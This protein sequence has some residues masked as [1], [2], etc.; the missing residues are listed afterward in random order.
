MPVLV[1]NALRRHRRVAIGR[2]IKHVGP[3]SA[4]LHQGRHLVRYTPISKQSANS[5]FSRRVESAKHRLA[6]PQRS[7]RPFSVPWIAEPRAHRGSDWRRPAR[8]RYGR[9]CRRGRRDMLHHAVTM[10]STSFAW[11]RH[12]VRTTPPS[13]RRNHRRPGAGQCEFGVFLIASKNARSR[14]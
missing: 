14:A 1:T 12:G 7:P 8:C 4:K 13:G 9:E 6:L 10:V 11:C 2:T 5:R 3:A